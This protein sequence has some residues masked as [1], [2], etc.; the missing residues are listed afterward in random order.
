MSKSFSTW[1]RETHGVAAE[2]PTVMG[3]QSRRDFTA[4]VR[5]VPMDAPSCC[6]VASCGGTP[7]SDSF[8]PLFK[9]AVSVVGSR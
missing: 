7:V 4:L 1:Y 3:L 8:D 5:D 6:G 9:G 2:W